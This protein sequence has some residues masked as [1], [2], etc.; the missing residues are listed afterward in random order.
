MAEQDSLDV[1]RSRRHFERTSEPGGRPKPAQGQNPVF[2]VQKHQATTLHYDFR[3]AVDGV[4]K[5]WAVPKGPP[6]AAGE[7]RLAVPTEDHP[8]EYADFAGTIPAGEYGAGQ[9]EIWDSGMYTNITHK[10]DQVI[11][12]GP[13][14]AAGHIVVR[15]EGRKLKGNFA[16]TRTGFGKGGWLMVKMN[17]PPAVH[18][19]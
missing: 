10:D 18:S 6:T 5:S 13:A 19:H 4:L 17:E 15:L 9:V 16:L 2:V 12:A 1:Y 11:P 14:I 3:L 7:K 8:L